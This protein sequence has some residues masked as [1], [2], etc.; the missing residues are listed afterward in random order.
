MVYSY[1]Y[2]APYSKSVY[3]LVLTRLFVVSM[4]L[5]VCVSSLF[6]VILG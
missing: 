2:M 5:V 6:F 1:Y 3:F 4:L